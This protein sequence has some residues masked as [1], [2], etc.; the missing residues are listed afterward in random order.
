VSIHLNSRKKLR[1]ADWWVGGGKGD[2]VSE[3]QP[4]VDHEKE[5]RGHASQATVGSVNIYENHVQHLLNDSFCPPGLPQ[6]Y[7]TLNISKK[8]WRPKGPT[9]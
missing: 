6:T 8:P 2:S 3:E 7:P 1:A 5:M 4:S 9:P